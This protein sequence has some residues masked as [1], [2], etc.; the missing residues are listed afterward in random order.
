MRNHLHDNVNKAQVTHV[1]KESII[2]EGRCVTVTEGSSY[3]EMCF[4]RIKCLED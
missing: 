4:L 2:N 3:I 1:N